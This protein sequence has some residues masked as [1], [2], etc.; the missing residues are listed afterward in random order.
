HVLPRMQKGAPL[1]SLVPLGAALI[2]A[3]A[4]LKTAPHPNGDGFFPRGGASDEGQKASGIEGRIPANQ[5]VD[6]AEP[7]GITTVYG[8]GE[9]EYREFGK[10]EKIWRQIFGLR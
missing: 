7:I 10:Y 9:K 3:T 2:G 6:P 1:N 5:K 4:V 8:L